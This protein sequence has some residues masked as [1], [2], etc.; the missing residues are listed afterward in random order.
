MD[1]LITKVSEYVERSDQSFGLYER[2][3]AIESSSMNTSLLGSCLAITEQYI[4]GVYMGR[5]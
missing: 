4:I 1:Q 3:L 2:A 5:E